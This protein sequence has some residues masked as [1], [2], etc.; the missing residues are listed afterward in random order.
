MSEL[1]ESKYFRGQGPVFIGGRDANGAP[2]GLTFIG[3]ASAVDLTPNIE[4]S[5]RIENVSGNSG[6]AVSALKS[7][8]YGLS[9]T[10]ASV[11]PAHLALALAGSLTAVTGTAVVDESHTAYL[12]KFTPMAYAKISAVTVTGVGGTPTYVEDTDYVVHADTGMIEFI[13]GGTITDETAVLIDYTF[14]TQSVIKTDPDNLERY[15]VFAGMNV[16]DNDKQTRCEIYKCKIDP[17]ALKLITDDV[18]DMTLGGTVELDSLRPA[19]DQLFSWKME[20]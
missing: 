3:D 7:V 16:A 2:T 12:D 6:V 8:K 20:S 1:F 14:A 15:I 9:M 13:S 19:G 10:L 5:E 11:K 18:T 4:R 17:S